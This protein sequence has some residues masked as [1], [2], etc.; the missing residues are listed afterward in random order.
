MP[1]VQPSHAVSGATSSGGEASFATTASAVL[2]GAIAPLV[3]GMAPVLVGAMVGK[4]GFSPS[5]A[6]LVI[7]AHLGG[8][9]LIGLPM[10]LLVQK[11]V[12]RK[13]LVAAIPI[14]AALFVAAAFVTHPTLLALTLFG[15]GLAGGV[16]VSITLPIMSRS[17]AP[18]Q[19]FAW[20]VVLQLALGSAGVVLL[21]DVVERHGLRGAFLIL[22]VVM[23]AMG[24]MLPFI[25]AGPAEGADPKVASAAKIS[26]LNGLLGLLGLYA[27]YV[28]V[29]A[30]WTYFERIGDAAGL[31]VRWIAT[32]LSIATLFGVVGAALAAF[33]PARLG[34]LGPLEVGVCILLAALAVPV[35]PL[36]GGV[37]A[38]SAI[39]FKVA[40]T[41]TLPF[42]L[43][44]LSKV[45]AS[46]RLLV[47]A[48]I[49]IGLGLA[50]G[51]GVAAGLVRPGVF[52]GVLL[53][54][55]CGVL[56]C[57]G[58]FLLLSLRLRK[59]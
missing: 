15:A 33:T 54:G 8:I 13:L 45:D 18:T 3:L 50:S 41:F 21:P 53:L 24:L 6:G 17:K 28:A 37:Y 29:G 48:N 56:L 22:A 25:P 55:V 31:D 59:V 12:W 47:L 20:W 30:V 9:G 27:F 42:L 26:K 16:A 52:S 49:I 23:G 40:W 1:A 32:T 2:M 10:T 35:G 39:L 36:S 38:G 4:L 5:Q 46:G 34:N 7:S 11:P 44:S 19:A 58:A 57:G 43:G 51:P 14:L